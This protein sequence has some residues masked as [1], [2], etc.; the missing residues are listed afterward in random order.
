VP[1]FAQRHCRAWVPEKKQQY[2]NAKCGTHAV[3]FSVIDA[4]TASVSGYALSNEA[5]TEDE[6]HDA[7]HTAG[8]GEVQSF[9]SLTGSTVAGESDLM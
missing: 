4:E 2:V 9:P 6:L 8:F 5:Y 1:H 3:R 7:L